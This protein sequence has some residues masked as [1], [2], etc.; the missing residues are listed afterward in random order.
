MGLLDNIVNQALDDEVEVDFSGAKEG[1]GL[2]DDVP[3]DEYLWEVIGCEKKTSKPSE[4]NPQGAPMLKV[5][6]A[7]VGGE[8]DGKR[9]TINCMLQGGGAGVTRDLLRVLGFDVDSPTFK[10]KMGDTVGKRFLGTVRQ[11]KNDPQYQ[12]I[13]KLKAA[14]SGSRLG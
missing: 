13:V 2:Y 9:K 8:Y 14:A 4:K 5:D 3:H 11:Q 7:I 10:L 12:E 1:G 6:V